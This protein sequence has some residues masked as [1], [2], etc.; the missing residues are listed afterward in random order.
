MVVAYPLFMENSMIELTPRDR[1]LVAL[2]AA[3]GSNCIACVEYHVP[4]ARR[5]G[6]SEAQIEAAIR[7]AD[8]LRQVPARKTLQAAQGLLPSSAATACGAGDADDC[9]CAA[10]SGSS[11]ESVASVADKAGAPAGA[12]MEMMSR[13]I[14]AMGCQPPAQRAAAQGGQG[15][16]SEAAGA[17]CACR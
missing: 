9:G 6:L 7:L 4:Q 14:D 12:M 15:A 16:P 2:G 17:G 13:M 11:A 1:E 3:M 8:K 5:V 10:L